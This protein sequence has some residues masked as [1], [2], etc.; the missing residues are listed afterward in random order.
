MSRERVSKY[1]I[2]QLWS[3]EDNIIIEYITGN[4]RMYKQ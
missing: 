4:R 1:L 2:M 3:F